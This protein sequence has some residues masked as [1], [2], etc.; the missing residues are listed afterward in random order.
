VEVRVRKAVR[1]FSSDQCTDI[2]AALT[3]FSVLAL[4]PALIALVSLLG[5]FGQGKTSVNALLSIVQDVAPGFT[6]DLLRGPLEQFSTSP[7]AGFA[8]VSGTLLA[9]WS[10][11]GYVGAFSRAMNRIYEVRDGRPFWKLRSMQLGVTVLTLVLIVIMATLLVVSGPV[12]DAV[13]KAL[14]VGQAVQLARAIVKWPILAGAAILVIAVLY[15]ATPNA[16][17]PRFRWISVGASLALV[18]LVVASILFAFYVTT[19]SNYEKTYG[20]LAGIVV[21]LLWLWIG[22]IALLFGAEFDAELERGRELQAGIAAEVEIQLP[23]R[24]TKESAKLARKEAKDIADGRRI[25]E[26]S[27]GSPGSHVVDFRLLCCRGSCRNNIPVGRGPL[28][29][30][31]LKIPAAGTREMNSADPDEEHR[32]PGLVWLCDL[33]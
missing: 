20:S 8:L 1:E 33:T 18:A 13:G 29:V 11:S 15:F 16:K 32:K 27:W 10:A 3:F 19:F 6:V 17:Q 24:D 31:G 2:A 26:R 4:F 28:E 25:R 7:A 21:F 23:A 22:N 12:A 14:G 30:R 5:V 9:I